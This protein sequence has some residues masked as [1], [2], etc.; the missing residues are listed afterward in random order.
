[1][2]SLLLFSGPVL[3]GHVIIPKDS[4]IQPPDL[5]LLGN[6]FLGCGLRQAFDIILVLQL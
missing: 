5:H 1:M 6:L 3:A 4:N 2:V